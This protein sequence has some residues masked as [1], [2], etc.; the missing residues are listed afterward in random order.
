MKIFWKIQKRYVTL[1]ETLIAL[2]LLTVLLLI[3]FTF[4]K[5]MSTITNLTEVKQKESFKLRYVESRLAFFF[6]RIVNENQSG[7]DFYFFAGPTPYG[8]SSFASLV[9]TY[10]NKIR[11]D[12]TFS[13]DVLGRLYVDNQK[14]L[15]MATWP[16]H[17]DDPSKHM[18]KEVL[19]EN[20]TDL[21]FHLYA[22]P[23]KLISRN[24]ISAPVID[25]N[26]PTR[27][28]WYT[29]EWKMAFQEMPV[30]IEIDIAIGDNPV[31]KWEF[32]FVL[33]SSKFP[34][35]YPPG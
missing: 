14:N 21:K 10:D 26:I 6:E 5:E 12:P 27:N 35:Y 11:L 25:P 31:K 18:Q 23:E 30:I 3:I 1:L 9:F 7:R 13:G 20:V 4:F 16:L 15:C 32:A 2:S 33:P 34:I 28:H 19:L 29:D 24:F 17:A 22:A 8:Q